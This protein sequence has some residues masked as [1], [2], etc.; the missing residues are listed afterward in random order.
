MEEMNQAYLEWVAA[1]QPT[2]IKLPEIEP[3]L[4]PPSGL[5]AAW[6]LFELCDLLLYCGSFKWPYDIRQY[7]EWDKRKFVAQYTRYKVKQWQSLDIPEDYDYDTEIRI[8]IGRLPLEERGNA[9]FSLVKKCPRKF[10]CLVMTEGYSFTSAPMWVTQFEDDWKILSLG[11]ALSIKLLGIVCTY[12][13]NFEAIS[14][15]AGKD[16]RCMV[17]GYVPGVQ[18][19]SIMSENAVSSIQRQEQVAEISEAVLQLPANKRPRVALGC[20]MLEVVGVNVASNKAAAAKLIYYLMNGTEAEKIENT[21][22]LRIIKEIYSTD[23]KEANRKALT[24]IRPLVERLVS[25]DKLL[26]NIDRHID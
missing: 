9:V 11:R 14:N 16:V 18:R 17:P 23:K 24:A 4:S 20:A 22:E 26:D 10:V 6:C 12:G 25:P 3:R 19:L 15:R 1:K 13:I 5:E 2:P 21:T 7:E 8:E